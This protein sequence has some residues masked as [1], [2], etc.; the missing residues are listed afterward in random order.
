MEGLCSKQDDREERSAK[1]GDLI[2]KVSQRGGLRGKVVPSQEGEIEGACC[3]PR[4]TQ[5][6]QEK[7]SPSEP[8]LRTG[9]LSFRGYHCSQAS[10]GD[11]V[12]TNVLDRGQDNR[13]ATG[14]SGEHINLIGALPH[15]AK[16]TLNGIGGL[17]VSVHGGREVIKRERLLFLLCQTSHRFPDNAC[18][19]W[20]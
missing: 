17:N 16:Q 9:Y 5:D 10:Q 15:I 4:A 1:S 2:N 12:Q 11:L 8:F 20:L 14:L 3:F 18:C 7:Q 13:Q 19:I 6:T